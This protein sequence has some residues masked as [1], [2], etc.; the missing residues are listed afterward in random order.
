[1]GV[2]GAA[3]IARKVVIPA[4]LRADGVEL[5]AIGSASERGDEFVAEA[6]GQLADSQV[7]GAIVRNHAASP[8]E[9]AVHISPTIVAVSALGE[10]TWPAAGSTVAR[11]NG[12]AGGASCLGWPTAS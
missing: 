2:L 7:Y 5:V 4:I 1:M 3:N 8:A 10:I 9:R 12:L 11:L 6:G